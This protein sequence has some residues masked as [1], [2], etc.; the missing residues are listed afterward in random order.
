M[1]QRSDRGT[2]RL[3][4]I[5]LLGWQVL[6]PSILISSASP[7]SPVPGLGGLRSSSDLRSLTKRCSHP[8][9][10]VFGS[11]FVSMA[12]ASAW[13]VAR[14]ETTLRDAARSVI[15]WTAGSGSR[16]HRWWHGYSVEPDT[17]TPPEVADA[18]EGKPRIRRVCVAGAEIPTTYPHGFLQRPQVHVQ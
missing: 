3:G 1:D 12:P 11:S 9:P 13:P 10:R 5:R 17:C 18:L 14:V 6:L 2:R 16:R 7:T 15:R 4:P 8:G